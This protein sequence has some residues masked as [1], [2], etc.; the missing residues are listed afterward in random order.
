MEKLNVNQTIVLRGLLR[1]V[2]RGAHMA[3]P[4]FAPLCPREKGANDWA[5]VHLKTLHQ[6]G[7]AEPT[8]V[9]GGKT[10]LARTWC[11]TPAGVGA[12]MDA[13]AGL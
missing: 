5:L 7:F 4:D 1:T 3:T 11:I 9:M 6:M 2:G 10:G 13:E 8:P 12:L